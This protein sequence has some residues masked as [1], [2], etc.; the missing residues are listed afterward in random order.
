MMP[1]LVIA[2]ALLF[3][4]FSAVALVDGTYFHIWKYKLYM[5]PESFWEHVTHTLNAALFPPTVFLLLYR[6]VAGRALWLAVVVIAADMAVESWDVLIERASRASLGGLTPIEYLCHVFAV[7]FRVGGIA[8]LLASKS[9]AAW[10][11]SA[12]SRLPDVA[13]AAVRWIALALIAGSALTAAQHVWLMQPRFRRG[14]A[15]VRKAA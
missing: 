2:G 9:A 13:P 5:R 15:E 14:R 7:T 6:N 11:W 12:P 3:C 8:V 1:Q 10:R 4:C